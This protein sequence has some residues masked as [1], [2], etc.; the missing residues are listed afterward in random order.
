MTSSQQT[1][2][3]VDRDPTTDE[4]VSRLDQ[5]PAGSWFGQPHV[6]VGEDLGRRSGVVRLHHVDIA[7]LYSRLPIDALGDR[8]HLRMLVIEG[9]RTHGGGNEPDPFSSTLA[10]PLLRRHYHGGSAVANRRA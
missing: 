7:R 3:R 4:Y 8:T 5:L 1:A 10:A 9:I 2:A 6:F